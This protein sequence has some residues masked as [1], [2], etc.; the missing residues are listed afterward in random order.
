MPA[1]AIYTDS[2]MPTIIIAGKSRILAW[3]AQRALTG[4]AQA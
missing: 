2:A 3:K 1:I 4:A